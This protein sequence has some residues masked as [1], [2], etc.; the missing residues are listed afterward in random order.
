MSCFSFSVSQYDVIHLILI[1]IYTLNSLLQKA[2]GGKSGYE[3]VDNAEF[4]LRRTA[5]W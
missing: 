3:S 5:S 4:V 1:I 2:L